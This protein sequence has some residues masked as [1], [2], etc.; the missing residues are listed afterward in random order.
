MSRSR[1]DSLTFWEHL[2]E[3]RIRLF[4]MIIAVVVAASVAYIWREKLYDVL[5]APLLKADPDITLNYFA[6][7]E[8][9]FVYLKIALFAGLILASPVVFYELWAFISPAL[10]PREKLVTKGM[11]FPVVV[12]FLGGVS[13]VYFVLLPFSLQFLLGFAHEKLEPELNQDKY[14]S[15]ITGLCLAGGIL[16]ELPVVLGLLGWLELVNARWLWQKTGVALV[17]LMIIAAVI[18][19]TGDAFNMLALTAPLL[20]LYLVGI[21]VVWLIQR[22]KGKNNPTQGV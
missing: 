20:G 4:R 5:I 18:T 17:V 16:F 1:V 10:N 2:T 11:I 7:T 6:P 9:F 13:F 3:L 12:L 14:F 15:F 8:P 21:V 22:V 19:P